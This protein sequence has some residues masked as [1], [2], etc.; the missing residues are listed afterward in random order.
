VKFKLGRTAL[1]VVGIGVFVI[2]FVALFFLYGQQSSE[3][4]EL[5]SSL[6]GAQTQLAKLISGRQSLETRLSEQ[7]SKLAETQ[8]L[9]DSAL[10]SFPELE[11]SIEY[12]EVLTELA[13]DYELEVVS[14]AA[15]APREKEVE[16]VTFVV[17]FFEVKVEGE[18]SSILNMINAIATDERFSSATIETIDIDIPEPELIVATLGQE[19]EK[20]SGTI[21]LVGYSYGGE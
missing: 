1:L 11:A 19:P 16:G 5:E 3:Q 7:Q 18:L 20:S 6:A 9:L 21:K 2:A 10:A 17:I 13:E 14:M 4:E 12:N 8:A 15:D